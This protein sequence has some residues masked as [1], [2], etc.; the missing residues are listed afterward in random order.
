MATIEALK[1]P[2]S[3]RALPGLLVV[4]I[5]ILELFG[6]GY[7]ILCAKSAMYRDFT[8]PAWGN[9]RNWLDLFKKGFFARL[10]QAIWAAPAVLTFGIV[11]FKLKALQNTLFNQTAITELATKLNYTNF[12][13][14]NISALYAQNVSNMSSLTNISGLNLSSIFMQNLTM[15]DFNQM[16]AEFILLR[17]LLILILIFAILFVIFMPASVLNYAAEEKFS[18]AFSLSMFKR[19]ITLSYLKGWLISSIYAVAMFG[20]LATS[21]LAVSIYASS[22]PQVLLAAILLA[23]ELF[24]FWIPGI[25]YWSILGAHWPVSETFSPA[26]AAQTTQQ[27]M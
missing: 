11:W 24:F 6:M 18:S 22:L 8:L 19:A 16:M 20:L 1:R 26:Q 21:V 4:L 23:L 14:T 2:F 3:K 27:L 7:K 10:I 15:V 12:T 17:N 25:T 9:F 13:S 5:P